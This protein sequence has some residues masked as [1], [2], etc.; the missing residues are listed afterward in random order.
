[1]IVEETHACIDGGAILDGD[2][3]D[4]AGAGDLEG[5]L[6]DFAGAG[7]LTELPAITSIATS[8]GARKVSQRAFEIARTR[9]VDCVTVEDRAAVGACM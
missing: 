9:P 7:K 2:A 1:M 8:L 3:I 5:A 6:A 4:G